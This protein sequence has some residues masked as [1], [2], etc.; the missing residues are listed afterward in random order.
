MGEGKKTKAK[1]SSDDAMQCETGLRASPALVGDLGLHH[2]QLG[3]GDVGASCPGQDG[4]KLFLLLLHR[5]LIGRFVVLRWR[6]RPT[7][8]PVVQFTVTAGATV[9]FPLPAGPPLITVSIIVAVTVTISGPVEVD[10]QLVQE[11]PHADTLWLIYLLVIS[12]A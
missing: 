7:S 6:R 10:T 3:R 9:P 1:H 2:A 8:P 5:G 11:S 12:V 4:V